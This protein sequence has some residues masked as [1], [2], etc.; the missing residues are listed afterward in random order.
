MNLHIAPPSSY[1]VNFKS[2]IEEFGLADNNSIFVRNTEKSKKQQ[3]LETFFPYY[4]NREILNKINNLTTNDRLFVHFLDFE[5][6]KWLTNNSPKC[7]VNW[8]FWGSDF[9]KVIEDYEPSLRL[10]DQ[11]TSEYVISQKK[12]HSLGKDKLIGLMKQERDKILK[13]QFKKALSRID[14]FLNFKTFEHDLIKKHFG[15]NLY[16]K[17]FNYVNITNSLQTM[18]SIIE[19]N[20]NNNRARVLIGNSASTPN[21][22]LDLFDILPT[23]DHIEY[24]VPLSYGNNEYRDYLIEHLSSRK[25]NIKFI[26]EFMPYNE[27]LMLTNSCNACIQ[28]HNRAQAVANIDSYLYMKKKVFLKSTNPIFNIYTS[29]GYQLFD[30]THISESNLA[31]HLLDELSSINRQL[32]NTKFN[33]ARIKHQYKELFG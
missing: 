32:I 10:H 33:K 20:S 29:Q 4:T 13:T 22:H 11:Q 25:L 31:E 26:T 23:T 3:F 21:N 7:E 15:V 18:D 28:W 17:E 30:E 16:Y 19:S 1:T 2:A 14:N 24:V 8:I 9:Y 27:Y 12:V 5:L 6:A